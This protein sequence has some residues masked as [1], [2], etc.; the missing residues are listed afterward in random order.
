MHR[1]IAGPSVLLLLGA[2]APAAHAQ[3]SASYTLNGH[4]FA[5]Y[6]LAG[7]VAVTAAAGPELRVQV[8]RQ[9]AD[10]ERLRVETGDFHG[11]PA[12]RVIYPVEDL[13]YSVPGNERS[14]TTLR[15]RD[16]GTF[17]GGG[18]TIRIRGSGDGVR[19]SADL[20]IGLPRGAELDVHLAVGRVTVRNTEGNVSVDVSSAGVEVDGLRG[21]F[22]LDG[23]SGPIKLSRIQ[24]QHISLD[25]GSGTVVATDIAAEELSLD[26]GSG[27]ASLDGV[28]V[29]RLSL[30]TG[31]GD[32]SISLETDVDRLALDSG[33]GDVTI[34]APAT[35][36]ARLAVDGGSGALDIRLPLK[37]RHEDEGTVTGILGD[38]QGTI[39]IDSGSGDVRLLPR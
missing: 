18:H 17:E 10:A 20:A 36:G 13:V 9:G 24:G 22:S 27:G 1:S 30:D 8:T 7:S 5:V 2:V 37:D 34:Y 14:E 12:L 3:A 4:T 11:R 29:D 33:S 38:G 25:T 16:D 6:D 23:G 31:S 19:A 32:V 21:S 15:L 28:S 26:S 39:T 35:L